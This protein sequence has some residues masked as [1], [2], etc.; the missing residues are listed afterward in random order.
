MPIDSSDDP[1]GHGWRRGQSG[2]DEESRGVFA[3]TQGQL[4]ERAYERLDQGQPSES[5]SEV[6]GE[7]GG[8]DAS[9]EILF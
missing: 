5:R 1:G 8:P 6:D 4:I 9:E 3:E 2:A 7:S